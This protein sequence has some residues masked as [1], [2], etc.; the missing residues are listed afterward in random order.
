MTAALLAAPL[1][2]MV[3]ERTQWALMGFGIEGSRIVVGALV[4]SL[5]TFIVFAFTIILL[6]V[7]IAGGQLTPRIIARVFESRIAKLILGAFVFS[8]TYTLAALGRI[9]DHVPQLPVLVAVLSSLFSIILFLYLIQKVSQG[10]R[11][12]M[13]LTHVGADTR[14]VINALYPGPFVGGTE[15]PSPEINVLPATRTIIHSGR[16]GVVLAFDAAGLVEIA[17]QAGCAIELVPQVGDFQATG[18]AIFR[19][20]GGKAGTMHDGSM[21]R[22]VMLGSERSLDN[23]PAFGFHI[24]VDIAIKALSPAINDPTTAVLAIDQLH[25][26]L[27]LLGERQLD[28]GVVRDNSGE[29]RI[30]YRTPCWEDFVTLAVTEI[31]LYGVNNPQVTRRFQVMFQQLVQV[32]PAQRSVA[33]HKEMAL[34]QRT[35]VKAF[36][37]PEDRILAGFGDLQGLGSRESGDRNRRQA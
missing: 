37:E 4:S 12:V 6:A 29:V 13:I 24:L 19:V 2:R 16:P 35:I 11:P 22:C 26:L 10:L 15:E 25:H 20:H 8:Y 21:S 34:L 28:P 27:H 36:V 23:D 14:S 31:R 1:V 3:D 7:Q 30:T 5:L 33:L 18:E 17:E 9:E 32:V